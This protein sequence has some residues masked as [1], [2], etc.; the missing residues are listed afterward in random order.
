MPTGRDVLWTVAG[1]MGGMGVGL[2]AGLVPAL[3]LGGIAYAALGLVTAALGGALGL[4][5]CLL[6]RRGWGVRELGF[7][8][9]SRSPWHLLWEVP[10]ALV[11]GLACTA[12]LGTL[13]G[14]APEAAGGT[15]T[16]VLT[17]TFTA[18]P[19]SVAVAGVCVVLLLPA[20]EEVVFRRVLLGWLRTRLPTLAAVLVV[21]VLFGAVHVVPVAVLYL[22]FLGLS[23]ALLFLWHR[24]LWAPVALHATN[25]A[26]AT[27]VAVLAAT[28]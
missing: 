10:V 18:A 3:L 8:A 9:G 11:A 26:L 7:V 28:S 25:N 13:L 27:V 6:R 14:L 19:W 4:W 2:V 20:V 16:D 23:A 1:G 24:S 5:L 22:T 17:S 21:S 15:D 12:T